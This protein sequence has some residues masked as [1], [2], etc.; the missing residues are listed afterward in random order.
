MQGQPPAQSEK[1][2]PVSHYDKGTVIQE[3]IQGLYRVTPGGE[4]KDFKMNSEAQQQDEERQ[5]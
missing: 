3:H 5:R 1:T 4:Q 2:S